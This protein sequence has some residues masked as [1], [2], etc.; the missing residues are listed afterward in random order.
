MN[1][2]NPST[3]IFE[4]INYAVVAFCVYFFSWLF[5]YK[6]GLN[7]LSIQSE[8]TLPALI[9]PVTIIKEGTLYADSFYK[10]LLSRYPH[11]DDK[12]YSKG[13]VPFYFKKITT[14]ETY[15]VKFPESLIYLVD[16]S[17]NQAI[18]IQKLT[19]HYISAFPIVAGLMSLPIYAVPLSLGHPVTWENL[20]LWSHISSALIVAISVGF[21]YLLVR[22]G[23]DVSTRESEL[24]TY[25]YGFGTIN[26]ALVSQSLWQHG[27]VQLF[28][29]LSLIFVQQIPRSAN[30]YI[31]LFLCGL[32]LS[33]AV[34]SRPT[35]ALAIPF[36][37]ILIIEKLNGLNYDHF[38][39]FRP[40]SLFLLLKGIVVP[41]L[42]FVISFV[43]T[44][45]FFYIYNALYFVDISN[46]GYA[47]QLTSGWLTPFPNGFLGLWLSPSK[48]ILVYSPIFIFS[49]LSVY[50]ISKIG[51]YKK[52]LWAL[53]FL[54]IVLL[55]TVILGMWKHWYGG[56]SFGYRMAS[57]VIPFLTL[58]LIPAVKSPKF[59]L[60]KPLFN[61]VV[62]FSILVQLY[63]MVFFDGIWHSAYDKG[64][65]DTS[66]LWSFGDSEFAF[67]IRRVMVKLQ[68]LER[69][70]P[71]CSPISLL[72][73]PKISE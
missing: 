11:P 12:D 32:F 23:F 4:F 6:I 5:V 3:K 38:T 60:F 48:G 71:Q 58:L 1:Q 19:S 37:L 43:P 41:I 42:I 55:H 61:V 16:P 53:V 30:K 2:Y 44:L 54:A 14:S 57:D 52:N 13:M 34:L 25:I 59:Y 17:D 21:F 27:V 28:L 31:N 9:M 63:G 35:A 29:I 56:W 66:W 68:I 47:S 36:L 72:E 33:F 67:N 46:Q 65:K 64:Y 40:Q 50:F 51:G 70:C 22:Y 8:D 62:I 73:A 26:F 20:I 39:N 18:S 7:T 69:A 24:L 45:V 15:S 10:E 49:L